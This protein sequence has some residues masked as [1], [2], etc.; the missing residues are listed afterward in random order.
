MK[1]ISYS[2]FTSILP[3][4]A[5]RMFKKNQSNCYEEFIEKILE[6]DTKEFRLKM[7]PL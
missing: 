4:L 5:E 3:V 2:E 7:K 6:L 1:E